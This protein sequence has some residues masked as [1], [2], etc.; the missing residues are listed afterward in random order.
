MQAHQEQQ[1]IRA[2]FQRLEQTTGFRGEIVAEKMQGKKNY[3][4]K[5][6]ITWKNRKF[7]YLAECKSRVDR[8][9]TINLVRQQMMEQEIPGLLVAPFISE[10]MAKACQEKDLQ[11]LDTAG[12]AY[13]RSD[14]MYVFIKGERKTDEYAYFE[15]NGSGLNPSAL[16]VMFALLCVPTLARSSYRD[17][18]RYSNVALGAIGSIIDGLKKRDL[19]TDVGWDKQRIVCDHERLLNEWVIAYPSVLRPKLNKRR[20]RAAEGPWPSEIG[21][22]AED[23]LWG[24]EVAAARITHNLKP[25]AYTLYVEPN[26]LNDVVNKFVRQYRLRPDADGP[27][28][29]LSSFWSAD[30]MHNEFSED[31]SSLVPAVLVYADLIASNDPRNQEVAA[32]V[33]QRINDA[34]A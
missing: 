23:V 20:F 27:I 13:L 9:A 5:V 3:D 8:V 6:S 31:R 4:A 29:I 19:I 2:A 12:N 18:A 22:E 14:D 32:E 26:K 34:R 1:L 17:I 24:G 33:R 28:E 7:K 10:S 16:K 11:F 21:F 30:L 15:N 25:A